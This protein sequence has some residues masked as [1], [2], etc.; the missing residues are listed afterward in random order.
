V[1]F[2][3]LGR[4][5]QPG[6]AF[7]R[8]NGGLDDGVDYLDNQSF[9][10][11]LAP[12]AP[13]PAPV[14]PTPAPAAGPTPSETT[15]APAAPTPE[16]Q[17]IHCS[18][19]DSTW[20]IIFEPSS[21]VEDD[22]GFKERC[23]DCS[24]KEIM[25][26]FTFSLFGQTYNS[27]YINMNGNL[28]FGGPSP[29]SPPVYF[30]NSEFTLVAPFWADVDNTGA[31]EVYFNQIGTTA[32]AVAWVGVGYFNGKTDKQ[33][34]FQVIIS[35]GGPVPGTELGNVCFCYGDMQ[36]TAGDAD[37]L[38]DSGFGGIPA[39][40]GANRGVRL[41]FCLFAVHFMDESV[42]IS[43]LVTVCCQD[44][45]DFFEFGRFDQP[46]YAFNGG[47]GG[48]DYLDNQSYC[49][50]LAPRNPIPFTP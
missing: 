28:S 39:V 45:V 48:V 22:N 25:L 47:I 30:P 5:N 8:V 12:V 17:P 14:A 40:V 24:S 3:Q 2:F 23:D 21:P 44:G 16:Q 20:T 29:N 38:D 31:G 26:P 43:C 15:P 11:D 13:P 6:T 42:L 7:D 49:F 18:N 36:W 32:F 50:D 1:E 37:S 33:N 10:Y 35:D 34:T 4:F 9:C 46:G 41:C 19:V 27:V